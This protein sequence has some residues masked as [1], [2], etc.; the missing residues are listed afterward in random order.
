MFNDIRYA[1]RLLLK[2]RAFATAA[3]L[4]LALCIGANTAMFSVIDSILLEPLPF[5]APERLVSVYNSYPRSGVERGANAV[6]D[7]YDRRALPAFEQLALYQ[8]GGRT[9]GESGRATRITGLA[10]TP[11]FFPL[12]GVQPQL[13]RAFVPEEGEPGRETAVI[14]S[15]GLWQEQ[16]AGAADV[17]G[18]TLRID[19]RPH[20][21]VGVMPRDFLFGDPEIA[22]WIP[23]AFT[24]DDR[25]D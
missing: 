5:R 4:T 17:V 24:A 13:G 12:L 15:W 9:V 10:V 20:T 2:H 8:S 3:L 1:A 7:F 21:V 22:A 19:E 18:R 23:L 25:S 16:F 11:S 6:P 14:L